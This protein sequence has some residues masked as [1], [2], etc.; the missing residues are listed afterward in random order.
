MPFEN[1]YGNGGL[2]TTVGDL[3]TWNE[4]FVKPVVG[5]RAYV[6]EEQRPGR[7]NDGRSH[8]YGLGLFMRSYK[9]V[10]EVSH[11][12]STAGYRAFLTRYPEQH[13]SVAVL[14]N[15]TTANATE[16]AHQVAD[17][18]L[19]DRAKAPP[20]A[21]PTAAQL[22]AAAGLYRSTRSGETVTIGGGR[23]ALGNR[24]WTFRGGRATATDEHGQVETYERVETAKPSAET[25]R[26]YT[27]TYT[28]DEAE[29]ELVTAIEKGGLVLKRRPDTTIPLTPL[30]ADAFSG[31]QIGTIIFR[32]NASGQVDALSVVQERVWD[33]RFKKTQ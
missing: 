2:L 4:N 21:G 9:G 30:Y 26:S 12:G 33:L 28:S 16:L 10:P 23:N 19:G 7:F 29:T 8:I 31:P 1:V 5:D 17:I 20:S 15:V 13:L 6:A 25:L 32:K 22:A 18:Y 3:L 14:C 24:R 11:S 27:G